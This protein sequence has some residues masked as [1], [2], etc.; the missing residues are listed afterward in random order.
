MRPDQTTEAVAL[1]VPE[2]VEGI[3][4]LQNRF[5]AVVVSASGRINTDTLSD[6]I[7]ILSAIGNET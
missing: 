6:M 5:F 7:L 3:P 4:L 2:V 1:P